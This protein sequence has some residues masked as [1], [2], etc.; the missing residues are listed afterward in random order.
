[1]KRQG[2]WIIFIDSAVSVDKA[3]QIELKLVAFS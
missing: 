3:L 2:Q 1:M